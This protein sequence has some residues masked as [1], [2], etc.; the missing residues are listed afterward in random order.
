[1]MLAGMPPDLREELF[2]EIKA[3][4]PRD[5]KWREIEADAG[6]VAT[7]CIAVLA[8]DGSFF[9]LSPGTHDYA[10]TLTQIVRGPREDC[11]KKTM[12]F[13]CGDIVKA[14][15]VLAEMMTKVEEL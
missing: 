11:D 9:R 4:V 15:A 1:M 3:N 12:E 10:Q 8:L 14:D 2:S 7:F 13:L 5:L 6:K